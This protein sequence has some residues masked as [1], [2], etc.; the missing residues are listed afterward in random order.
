MAQNPVRE[1]VDE[2]TIVLFGSRHGPGSQTAEILLFSRG[3]LIARLKFYPPRHRSLEQPMR[4][5]TAGWWIVPWSDSEYDRVVDVLRNEDPVWIHIVEPHRVYLST[6]QEL[7]G[8]GE[9]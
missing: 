9:A 1:R 3:G 4:R 6:K 2:Y 8:E 7:V 5:G